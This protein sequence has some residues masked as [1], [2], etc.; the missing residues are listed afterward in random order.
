MTSADILSQLQLDYGTAQFQNNWIAQDWN[1]WDMVGYPAAGTNALNFFT[2]PAGGVDPNLGVPKKNEQT[3]LVTQ[4]QIGGD[5]VFI[6]THLRAFILN[7]AKSRQLGA[8]VATDATFA[9][10]QLALSRFIIALGSQGVLIWTI[11]QKQ[12]LIE[13]NPFQRFAAGFGLGV[14]VPPAIGGTAAITGGANAYAQTSPFDI[15]GGAQGDSFSLAQPVFLAPNTTFKIDITFPLGNS[16]A[17]TNIYG[18]G[19]DQTATIWTGIIL[20]GWKVRPRQ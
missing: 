7:S 15:D 10:R 3:N 1:Y 6:A 14:V 5:E 2:V 20:Q 17:A 19:A 11:L 12:W 8:G 18:A 9:A 4:N 16:P 13:A